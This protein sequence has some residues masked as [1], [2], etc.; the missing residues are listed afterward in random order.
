[1]VP[2]DPAHDPN[3]AAADEKLDAQGG[4]EQPSVLSAAEREAS[5]QKDIKVVNPW[6]HEQTHKEYLEGIT[7]L[8]ARHANVIKK[9]KHVVREKTFLDEQEPAQPK[10]Q[11]T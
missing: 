10:D 11:A 1:M 7:G 8:P 2:A 9:H 4:E 6:I 5:R 3:L